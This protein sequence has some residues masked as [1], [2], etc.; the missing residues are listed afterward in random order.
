[1][2]KLPMPVELRISSSPFFKSSVSSC[3]PMCV[4]VYSRG[5][6][7]SYP[8]PGVHLTILPN[9]TLVDVWPYISRAQR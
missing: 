3:I 5:R 6:P 1:L 8:A 7:F 9:G 4:W 2:K